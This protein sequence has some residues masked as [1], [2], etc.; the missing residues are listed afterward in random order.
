M[1]CPKCGTETLNEFSVQG[2]A[3]ER[4]SSCSGIWFDA[5]E[6]SQLLAEDARHVASL[7]RGTVKQQ[8]EGK[9]GFCPR[10]DSE[11]LRVYSSMDRS[12]ILDACA[13]CRGIWLDGGEF[14]KL[15]AARQL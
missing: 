1:K 10:D 6:L 4:C 13:E 9:K 5:R 7:R 12:V 15:F 8:L 14:E 11:L 3:V 2:V